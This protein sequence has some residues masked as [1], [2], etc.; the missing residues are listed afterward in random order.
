MTSSTL[1]SPPLL[2]TENLVRV[3]GAGEN[4]VAALQGLTFEIH[5]VSR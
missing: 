1:E 3:F 4:R 5:K 2:E